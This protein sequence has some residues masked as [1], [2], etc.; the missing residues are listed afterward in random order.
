MSVINGYETD[1]MLEDNDK[2]LRVLVTQGVTIWY[3]DGVEIFSADW[4]NVKPMF[5][6]LISDADGL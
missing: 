6:S 1:V 5:Q 3:L 2:V 4:E